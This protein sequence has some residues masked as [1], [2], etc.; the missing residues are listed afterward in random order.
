MKSPAMKRESWTITSRG[1]WLDRRRGDL[2]ASRIAALWDAHPYMSREQLG[3]S[4]LGAYNAGDSGSMRRGR[5]LEP[6]VAAGLAEE[7]PD[8]II[9]KATTYHRLPE[10]RIGATPDYWLTVD[11]V[12]GLIQCKT[13][14]PEAWETWRGRPPLGYSLQVLCELLAT[15]RQFGILAVMV[16]NRSLPIYEWRVPRHPAAEAR[17]LEAAAAW[18]AEWDAG[19]IAPAAPTEALE[20]M[21]DDGSSVDLSAD[22]YLHSAL[23]DRAALKSMISDA[24]KRCTEI[25]AHLK[26]AMGKATYGYLP[27]WAVTYRSHQRA[28]RLM[29]A[30]TIRTLR[31]S[32][33]EEESV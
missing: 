6:A 24:E 4:M 11:G 7:H 23:P 21:L 27:G 26:A 10:Y 13:C 33:K 18:W 30:A 28:E 22:N 19:R 1:E 25:D 31:V 2:T 14:S 5:I 17:L 16:T 15:D 9:E 8:W 3:A 29:P 20:T 32:P 12:D